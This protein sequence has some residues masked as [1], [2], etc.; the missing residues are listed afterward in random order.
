MPLLT[1]NP[2]DTTAH[3]YFVDLY[4]FYFKKTILYQ[5]DYIRLNDNNKL[6]RLKLRVFSFTGL[7]LT[8]IPTAWSMIVHKICV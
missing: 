7:M 4:N 1:Q 2:G 8:D 3:M 5:S 6:F